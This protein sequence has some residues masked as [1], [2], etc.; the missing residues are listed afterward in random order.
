MNHTTCH[1]IQLVT[2]DELRSESYYNRLWIATRA[3]SKS[4][5]RRLWLDELANTFRDFNGVVFT[6]CGE[7]FEIPDLDAVFGDDQDMRWF[8]YY[9]K[10]DGSGN[11]PQMKS[12]QRERLE[13]LDLYFKIKHPDIAFHFGR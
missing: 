6:P 7:A 12:R 8:S 1:E 2:I 9:L 4:V 13:L 11:Q 3:I 10:S 5:P